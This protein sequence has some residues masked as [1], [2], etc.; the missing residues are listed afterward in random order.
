[1]ADGQ[2]QLARI[3][4]AIAHAEAL[5]KQAEAT[6]TKIETQ[7]LALQKVVAQL[8]LGIEERS[9]GLGVQEQRL[10]EQIA[11]LTKQIGQLGPIAFTGGKI[12]VAEEVHAALKDAASV[13]KDAA[14]EATAPVRDTLT[15]S[16]SAIEGAR[17]S[18]MRAQAW[19]SWRSLAVIGVAALA[20]LLLAGAGGF[21]M[22][23]WQRA[24]IANA[25]GELSRLQ[26]RVQTVSATVAE[27]EK[28]GSE[29]DAKGVRFETTR[30]QEDNHKIRLCVE[31]D[32]KAPDFSSSDGSRKYRV[33][34]GF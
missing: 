2:N 17:A 10:A 28:K 26:D 13:L 12:A 32:P 30:C 7:S 34:I 9:K 23:K 16:L 8:L 4:A 15:A 29:L 24:E 33:P 25:K 3:G 31:I 14:K 22:I 19:F 27:M 1:M 6:Q 18:L 11:A 21:A 5:Q 20:A